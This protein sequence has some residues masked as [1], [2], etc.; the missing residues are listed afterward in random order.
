MNILAIVGSPRGSK[1]RTRQLVEAVATGA[2]GSGATVEVAD[3]CAMKVN[4]CT[5]CGVCYAEGRC[6]HRD[7]L[8]RL[9]PKILAAEG[10]VLGSPNYFRSV[11]AQMKAMIDRMSD[12]VHCQL[13]TGKYGCSVATSGGP[14]YREVTD[15]LSAILVGF[16]ASVVGSAGASASLPN[17]MK[18]AETEA[19]SLGRTLVAA[20]QSRR[21]YPEQEAVHRETR[22][23]FRKLV[24]MNKDL[25]RHEY[26]Y[27]RSAGIA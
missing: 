14:A 23:R 21:V 3:V 7:D 27:W 4:Y 6:V 12:T 10:L 18:I 19:E 13:L 5:G 22:D 15:Y 2:R 26:Q 11:S 9:Y 24:E 25:W 20:I 16:G 8:D 17:A 1:S